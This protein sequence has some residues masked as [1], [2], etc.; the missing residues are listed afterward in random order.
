MRLVGEGEVR[1]GDIAPG[2]AGSGGDQRADPSAVGRE[3]RRGETVNVQRDRPRL[4]L[5]PRLPERA[6]CDTAIPTQVDRRRIETREGCKG[7]FAFVPIAIEVRLRQ[8]RR[9]GLQPV[10]ALLMR[11]SA[12]DVVAPPQ[13]MRLDLT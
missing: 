7:G 8:L 5:Q 3:M 12:V 13:A 4:Q 10:V 11:P 1:L 9:G 6:V 2:R